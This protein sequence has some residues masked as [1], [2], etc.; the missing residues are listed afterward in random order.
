MENVSVTRLN[1]VSLRLPPQ[2]VKLVTVSWLLTSATILTLTQVT[3]YLHH[4][5]DKALWLDIKELL[6]I[7]S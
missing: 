1:M 3:S 7:C 6:I 5:D 4:E 2:R